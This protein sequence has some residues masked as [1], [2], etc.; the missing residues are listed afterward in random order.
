MPADE[1][2]QL[3]PCSCI[4]AS[5]Q[6]HTLHADKLSRVRPPLTATSEPSLQP[7]FGNRFKESLPH[8]ALCCCSR[9]L[10]QNMMLECA[11]MH[12]QHTGTNTC[13]LKHQHTRQQDAIPCSLWQATIPR[14]RDAQLHIGAAQLQRAH[15]FAKQWRPKTPSYLCNDKTE[16][17]T[18]QT[19]CTSIHANPSS[20][21]SYCCI[22]KSMAT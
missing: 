20:C 9:M 2:T 12:M 21:S 13:L 18:Q 22:S 15:G 3:Q 6:R 11:I 17:M 8:A 4:F 16:Y 7:A 1:R 5:S 19:H 14:I 10:L